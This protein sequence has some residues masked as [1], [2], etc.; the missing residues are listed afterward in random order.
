M[1]IELAIGSIYQELNAD[2]FL[3]TFNYNAH[4]TASDALWS[5]VPVLTKQGK[6]FSARVCSSLLTTLSLEELIVKNSIEYE[7]K[8][9]AIATNKIYLKDLK[10]RL[11][12][13][14]IHSTL[15]DT[16]RF[17]ENLEKYILNWLRIY[18]YKV[19]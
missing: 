17:T 15:F 11:N 3:D 13:K 19:C 5:G 14:R 7:K 6:S 1:P 12:Q 4:T 10:C 9:I 18:L 8:A 2:L 16:K